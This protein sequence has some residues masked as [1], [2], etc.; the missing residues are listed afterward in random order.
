M[1][2]TRRPPAGSGV[3]SLIW[4]TG[5]VGALA[6]GLVGSW[7]GA[8]PGRASFVESAA[9]WTGAVGGFA[10]GAFTPDKDAE[11]R[12]DNALLAGAIML[13]VGA[14]GG[15]VAAGPVSP[16]IARVRFIDLGGVGGA[17]VSGGIYWAAAND[18]VEAQPLLGIVALGST[19]GLAT[20]FLLTSGMKPDRYE[21]PE[22]AREAFRT[23]VAPVRGGAV[24]ELGGGF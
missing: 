19:A 23:A 18:D 3:A 7:R 11:F 15:I 14:I 16:S 12:D 1:C 13:N 5:T 22:D 20:S 4:A 21:R 9:L 17:L 24:L 6:G 8:T 10:V 2:A